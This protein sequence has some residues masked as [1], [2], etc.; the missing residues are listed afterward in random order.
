MPDEPPVTSVR[1]PS[2]SKPIV[3]PTFVRDQAHL[4]HS[5]P[6][7]GIDILLTRGPGALTSGSRTRRHDGAMADLL[8]VLSF[9]AF[10]AA[11]LGYIW[12]LERI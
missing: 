2:N 5:R 10:I 8:V 4:R 11:F 3:H 12:L 7:E 9:V 1:H 6:P